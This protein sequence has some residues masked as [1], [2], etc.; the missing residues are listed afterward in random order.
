MVWIRSITPPPA[1]KR[2]SR[3]MAGPPKTR[4]NGR[5][6]RNS[7]IQAGNAQVERRGKMEKTKPA[8]LTLV[9][10]AWNE[11]ESIEQAIREAT[12]ALSSFLTDYEIIVVDDGSTD[13]TAEIVRQAAA[14]DAHV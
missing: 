9:I 1:S 5:F 14:G 7:A 6:K 10:P 13:H 11:A 3:A 2:S 8:R 4:C 12:A